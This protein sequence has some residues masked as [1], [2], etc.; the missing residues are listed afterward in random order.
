MRHLLPRRALAA[1]LIVPALFAAACGGGGDDEPTINTGVTLPSEDETTTTGEVETTTTTTTAPPP[2]A[3]LTGLPADYDDLFRPALAIKIGN[4]D[5]KARPQTGINQADLVYE[6]IVESGKTRFLAVFQSEIP[7]AIGTVRS[8]RSSDGDLLRNL[9]RPLFANSGSNAGVDREMGN[10]EDDGEIIIVNH[11]SSIAGRLYYRTNDYP[12]PNNLY[13]DPND[14]YAL[15]V[16][17]QGPPAPVF[18]YRG[19]DDELPESAVPVGGVVVRFDG[20]SRVAEHYW[21]E[22]VG[23]WVRVQDGTIH[24]DKEDVEIAPQNVLVLTVPYGRSAADPNS[25]EAETVGEGLGTLFTD[26]HA[27]IVAWSRADA[28]DPFTLTDGDGDPV[29]LTPGR[30]WVL[31]ANVSKS[32]VELVDEAGSTARLAEVR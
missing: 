9:N 12:A 5:E 18:S 1:L 11:E 25:P 14:L 3:P 23:G 6:E 26:G 30:T 17:T 19:E 15:E 4:N 31:L 27:V 20:N 2:A 16:P 32:T 7:G 8:A 21:D 10:L 22:A 28:Q 24:V 29:L 13:V